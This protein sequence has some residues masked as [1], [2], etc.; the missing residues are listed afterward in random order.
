MPVAS[1]R[2]YAIA[3]GVPPPNHA[4]SRTPQVVVNKL[5]AVSARLVR[6]PAARRVGFNPEART[7]ELVHLFLNYTHES[8]PGKCDSPG[9]FRIGSICST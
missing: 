6:D 5:A 7:G 4:P 1:A 8:W 3:N 9:S 2:A